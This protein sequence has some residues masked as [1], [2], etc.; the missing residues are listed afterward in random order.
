MNVQHAFD[1]SEGVGE[2]NV[3]EED[4]KISVEW[5]EVSNEVTKQLAGMQGKPGGVG[6]GIGAAGGGAEAEFA[7]ALART[8]LTHHTRHAT[9]VFFFAPIL[10]QGRGGGQPPNGP[11]AR[12]TLH[13][14]CRP[15]HA[16]PCYYPPPGLI[17]S[18]PNMD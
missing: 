16:L 17:A 14:A 8:A 1:Q 6:V 18:A 5:S 12:G 11:M 7:L 3:V 10:A 9:C 2:R 4:R 13:A 15:A